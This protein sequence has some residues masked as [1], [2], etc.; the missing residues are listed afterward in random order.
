M[1]ITTTWKESTQK[2]FW[3][4]IVIAVAGLFNTVYDYVTV[5]TN[6][7]GML[8]DMLPREVGRGISSSLAVV[9]TIG[10]LVKV[11]IIVG[12]V[13]YLLG[14]TQFAAIQSNG[15]AAQNIQKVRTA[16]IILICCFAA[17]VVFGIL[18]KIPFVGILITLAIWVATL[19]AYI[20]MKNA[21]GVLMTSP[22][23]SVKSQAG[24]K[25]LRTA[26]LCNIWVMLLPI[27]AALMVALFVFSAFSG[28]SSGGQGIESLMYTGG[29]LLAL[30]L[31]CAIVL[32]IIALIYPFI[33]WYKIMTGGPGEDALTDTVEIEQRMAAIP[34]A[35]DQMKAVREKGEAAL[36]SAKESMVNIQKDM[37]PKLENAKSWIATHRKVLGIGAGAVVVVAL[38]AWIISMLG[39]DKPL[40]FELY[41][42]R[43]DYST[44][45][46]DIPQDNDVRAQNVTKGILDIIAHSSI[47]GEV[48]APK[49][50]TLEE[51][52]DD[53]SDRIDRVLDTGQ[54]GPA[55]GEISIESGYQNE[56]SVTFLV[57]DGIYVMGNPDFYH[58]VVRFSDGHVMEQEEMVTIPE[59]VLK[60]LIEKYLTQE[61]S[62]WLED[63]YWILPAPADSCRVSW[64]VSRAELGNVLIPL[65]E[66]EPYMTEEGKAIFS[67]KSL[68][69]PETE[70]SGESAEEAFTE[71]V[72]NEDLDM[73]P[74]DPND[75]LL[76]SLP[77]G[78]TEYV[79]DMVGFPIEFT[80]HKNQNG[81]SL[82]ADY[83]NV[84][85]STKMKLQGESMPADGGNISFFGKDPQ[86]NQWN[87][88]L[89]GDANHITGTAQSDG[90]ELKVTLHRKN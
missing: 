20:K 64:V 73:D 3:G 22:A 57:G 41:E 60:G 62:V 56:A 85:Y 27:I 61:Q 16:V 34:T 53:Y 88:Y 50:G 32:L 1:D 70:V 69:M 58:R 43:G 78:T 25:K 82:Q 68:K 59:D 76:G 67:A 23:F 5:V 9:N 17:T 89:G 46:V 77:E 74:G 10:G 6:V 90:K 2:I 35:D 7:V 79:G 28:M 63:G 37:A 55:R 75:G 84:K 80:I 48:G 72:A 24:A 45:C 38:I 39:G 33:G 52:V 12:Y 31:I 18:L 30:M 66:M 40:T 8:E 13:L 81:G 14:L 42:K 65:S 19:V 51:I 29:V 11:A 71:E 26:A 49:G 36:A 21:F 87:F 47:A 44:L 4:V 86:G 54:Y 83:R 15:L